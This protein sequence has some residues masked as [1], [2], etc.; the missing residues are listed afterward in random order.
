MTQVNP[1]VANKEAPQVKKLRMIGADPEV[2][3]KDKLSGRIVS[4]IGKIGG[5]KGQGIPISSDHPH[6]TWLEDNVAVEFNFSP[7]GGVDLFHVT[8]DTV[9]FEASKKLQLQNLEIM[10]VCVSK[11]TNTDLADPQAQA[12][13]CDPDF[14]AYDLKDKPRVVDP[15]QVGNYRFCGGHIHF[16]FNNKDKI[17]GFALAILADVFIGL[18]SLGYD[19]QNLR[20]AYYGKAGLYRPKPYGFEYRTM[21]NWWLRPEHRDTRYSMISECFC[22]LGALETAPDKVARIFDKIPLK[23]VEIIINNERT[24]DAHILWQEMRSNCANEGLYLGQYFAPR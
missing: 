7:C 6:I 12:F 14:D 8:V 22:L 9:L 13:G 21:S 11:F 19:K 16:G 3:L 18:P 1:E 2:F 20:R 23:D 5:K 17:P 4:S 24:K 10:P 15:N